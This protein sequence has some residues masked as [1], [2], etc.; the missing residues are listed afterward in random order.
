[1]ALI[2]IEDDTCTGCGEPLSVSMDADNNPDTGSH[3]YHSGLPSRCHA[4][5][6]IAAAAKPYQDDTTPAPGALRFGV[7]L[8][9]RG[10]LPPT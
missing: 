2:H 6:A 9:P 8:L 10:V 5:T 4:C 1:M 7:Q 3:R